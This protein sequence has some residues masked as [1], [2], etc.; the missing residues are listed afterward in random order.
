MRANPG[1]K[2]SV[3][4]VIGRDEVIELI[5]D[6]LKQQSV[7]QT[8][9]RRIGKTTIIEKM[10]A[11]PRAG[12]R[13]VF[14]DL[15]QYHTANDFAL[16]VY[17]QI[18]GFLSGR[19]R[20]ARRAM[21]FFR[22]MG[23]TEVS[24]IFKLPT[25]PSRAW[26]DILTQSIRD[27]NDEEEGGGE[28]LVFLWDEMPYMLEHIRD[29]EGEAVALEVLDVLR[30]LRQEH[31][32]RMVITGSVG[33][34]H[35]LKTLSKKA[36]ASINDLYPIEIPTLSSAD[37]IE[38]ASRL[39]Q[40]EGLECDALKEVAE[41]ISKETDQFPFYIHH[42]VKALKIN[43]GNVTRTEARKVVSGHL[44]DDNDPWKLHHFRQRLGEYYGNDEKIVTLLL[45]EL[46]LA[47]GTLSP[48]EL[49]NR[50][51]KQ[52]PFD[53]RVRLMEL[54]RLL[55]RDHYLTRLGDGSY[56]FRYS[57]IRRWWVLSGGLA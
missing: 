19:K 18:D 2:I 47:D 9:E 41:E 4:A 25:L 33:I 24:G 15:E 3:D 10:V 45:D 5:W 55:V 12:W 28:R 29:K 7:H 49:L 40:G 17:R 51:K 6:T 11:E 48:N 32:L 44:A 46:S 57:L 38:L 52:I 50:L 36:E 21:E 56:R 34:H 22:S 37:A 43:G 8:A 16:S 26:K 23:G 42:V 20:A 54:L 13:P 53:D 27:L 35:V 14:Q 1:G 31:G 39:I 30:G